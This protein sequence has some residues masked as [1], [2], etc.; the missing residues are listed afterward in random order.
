MVIYM[1]KSEARTIL[2][3]NVNTSQEEIKQAY[4]ILIKSYHPD[5]NPYLTNEKKKNF[6][7]KIP[8]S[9]RSI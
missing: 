3:V 5:K 9:T 7:P 8:A 2:G 6:Q 4:R 1:D